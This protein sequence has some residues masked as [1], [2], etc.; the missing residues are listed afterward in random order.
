MCD[1][2]LSP[3]VLYG[4]TITEGVLSWHARTVCG[5]YLEEMQ[6]FVTL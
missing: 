4:K 6:P 5:H 2:V 3:F 1:K